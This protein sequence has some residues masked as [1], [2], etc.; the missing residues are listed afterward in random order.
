M[1]H[2]SLIGPVTFALST[3]ARTSYFEAEVVG[4]NDIEITFCSLQG[5]FSCR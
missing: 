3:F 1:R 5:N 4:L 2:W